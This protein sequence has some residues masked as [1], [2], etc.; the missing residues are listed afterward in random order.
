RLDVATHRDVLL[1][2]EHRLARLG[3]NKRTEPFM[4]DRQI[5]ECH[6]LTKHGAPL[7]FTERR[8]DAEGGELFVATLQNFFA[9][10]AAQDVNQMARAKMKSA[11]SLCAKH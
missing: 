5:A 2:L 3:Q 7:R 6:E 1:A 4:V 8:T 10:I 11:C 9:A